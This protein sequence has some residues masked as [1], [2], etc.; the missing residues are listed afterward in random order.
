MS[1]VL[2]EDDGLWWY[3]YCPVHHEPNLLQR[4]K[5]WLRML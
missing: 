3:E 1:K 2:C 4:F 5:R